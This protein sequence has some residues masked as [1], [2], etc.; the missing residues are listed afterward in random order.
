MFFVFLTQM[1]KTPK[2]SYFALVAVWHCLALQTHPCLCSL[3]PY[4][5]IRRHCTFVQVKCG[6]TPLEAGFRTLGIATLAPK[7]VVALPDRPVALFGYVCG[8]MA[9]SGAKQVS[10]GM[11][12]SVKRGN[13]TA[14]TS[15]VQPILLIFL[16]NTCYIALI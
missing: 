6:D 11:G 8:G 12:A 16:Q 14:E 2:F 7:S 3:D 4:K 1:V 10:T 9:L 15:H 5:S 13:A